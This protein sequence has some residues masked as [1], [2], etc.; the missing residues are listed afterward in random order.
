M[1]LSAQT[2]DE[3]AQKAIENPFEMEYEGE[4]PLFDTWGLTPFSQHGKCSDFQVNAFREISSQLLLEFPE[5]FAVEQFD[6]YAME[7]IEFLLVRVYDDEGRPTAAFARAVDMID[8]WNESLSV[9]G[10]EEPQD[11]FT[12]DDEEEEEIPVLDPID[13]PDMAR[14]VI[15]PVLVKF[16]IV[17]LTESSVRHALA[18]LLQESFLTNGFTVPINYLAFIL[19]DPR[20]RNLDTATPEGVTTLV[21]FL[22][23][24]VKPY[25][26]ETS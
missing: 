3:F 24:E 22:A 9:G 4:Y 17:N 13:E 8:H 10:M 18:G 21:D 26:G 25:T 19:D 5:E 20:V 15:Y 23:I 7:W 6:H 1:T 14:D 16:G 12:T 11:P 2:L